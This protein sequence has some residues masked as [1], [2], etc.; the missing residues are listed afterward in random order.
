MALVKALLDLV[1]TSMANTQT[2]RSMIFN[3]VNL[4]ELMSW[5][6]KTNGETAGMGDL[7]KLE[8]QNIAKI[9][10]L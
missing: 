10:E 9:L 4:L 1:K 5:T 7:S 6:V 2:I 8:E 3:A